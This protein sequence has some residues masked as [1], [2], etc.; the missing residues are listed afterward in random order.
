MALP[1]ITSSREVG[2]SWPARPAYP[3]TGGRRYN[4]EH[5]VAEGGGGAR[6]H[7]DFLDLRNRVCEGIVEALHN[8]G[9]KGGPKA[10]SE[11]EPLWVSHVGGGIGWVPALLRRV[12]RLGGPRAS[13]LV[14]DGRVARP[15]AKMAAEATLLAAEID[16]L[17][18]EPEG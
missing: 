9:V 14:R 10:G 5:R 17:I 6:E 7:L 1:A 4:E 3:I 11:P 12:E 13:R 16:D 18:G 15:A 2:H 8:C